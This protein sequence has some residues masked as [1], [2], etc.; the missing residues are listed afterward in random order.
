YA[1]KDYYGVNPEFGTLDDFKGLIAEA[2]KRNMGVIVDW[3]PNHTAWD[4]E[5][6]LNR[7]WYTQ[8]SIGN[9]IHPEGTNWDDVAD[10]NFD[11]PDMRLAMIEAMKFWVTEVGVDGFRCD[12][13]D[14]VPFDFLKQCNDSLR[15]I[16]GKNLLMLAEG[17]RKDHFEAGFDLNYGWDFAVQMRKVYQEG[18][19]ASTL[20]QANIEEYAELPEGKL[21]LRFTTNHDEAT[22][23]SP[24]VEWVSEK[25]SMSAFASILFFPDVPMIYGSQ[26]VGYPT[27]INFFH[28][29]PV[30][31]QA[32]AALRNE[33]RKLMELYNNHTALRK[34]DFT[35]FP[36]KNILLFKRWNAANETFYIAINTR[37]STQ[38]MELPDEMSDRP[39]INLYTNRKLSLENMI[40]L[41]A[42]EYLILK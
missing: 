29:V 3:V 15:A 27:P 34:G 18:A 11:N 42:F 21:K 7:D 37:N 39:F 40:T 14:F 2:H 41:Q 4:N 10:L 36:D 17:S 23:H 8:D 6:I 35:F 28:Y 13:V 16:P 26:E 5:W 9:I 32:N 24:I 33:Y 19:D 1:V 20:Y 12:A 31:W 22:K 38:N 30:D 25:G